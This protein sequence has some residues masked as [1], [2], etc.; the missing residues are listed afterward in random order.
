MKAG[1]KK[2]ELVGNRFGRLVVKEECGRSKSGDVRWRCLCD[3]GNETTV[4]G[5]SLTSGYTK[6]C[7]CM[8]IGKNSNLWKGGIACEQYC[9]IWLDKEFKKSILERDNYQCQNS[10][11]WGTG[12]RLT[13]HH[14]DYNKKNCDTSNIITLCNSCN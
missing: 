3:C 7:G 2:Y 13:G 14:I 12:N 4:L 1:R 8:I 10:A 11:C 6:S 9:S 5:T